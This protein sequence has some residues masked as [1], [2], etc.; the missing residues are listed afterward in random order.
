MISIAMING[1]MIIY[2]LPREGEDIF[3]LK[4]ED[5]FINE[6]F[7]IEGCRTVRWSDTYIGYEFIFKTP[8]NK[9]NSEDI[10]N[11]I[12]AIADKIGHE[13]YVPLSLLKLITQRV[14]YVFNKRAMKVFMSDI[15]MKLFLGVG[16]LNYLLAILTWYRGGEQ[17]WFTTNC[18][19]A[20]FIVTYIFCSGFDLFRLHAK[21]NMFSALQQ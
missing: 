7:K 17:D 3:L 16:I 1:K 19:L 6:V 9:L 12:E 4:D 18:P 2:N 11:K 20:V 5:K 8:E 13:K 15:S 21:D 10:F 14:G